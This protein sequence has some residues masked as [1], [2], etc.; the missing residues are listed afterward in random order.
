MRE[1]DEGEEQTTRATDFAEMVRFCACAAAQDLAIRH[2]TFH[3]VYF[4][5]DHVEAT[6]DYTSSLQEMLV[7]V[8]RQ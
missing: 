4:G 8:R 3:Q 5:R 1:D 2:A 6:H 7:T